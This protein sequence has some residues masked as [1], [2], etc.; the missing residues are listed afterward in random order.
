VFG[1][2]QGVYEKLGLKEKLVGSVDHEVLRKYNSSCK[3]DKTR[4]I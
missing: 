1:K 2:G 4:P 3:S